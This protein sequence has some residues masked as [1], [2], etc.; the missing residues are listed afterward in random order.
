MC[1]KPRILQSVVLL[2]V[3]IPSQAQETHTQRA[4]THLSTLV[5]HGTDRYGE[6]QSPIWVLNLDLE[7]LNCFP[8]YNDD[9]ERLQADF[10]AGKLKLYSPVVPYGTGHRVL[11]VSQRPAGCSNPYVDQPT[12]RAALL[13]DQL[14]ESATFTPAV[15]A[16]IHQYFTKH[17]NEE[18]GLL[19]WGVHVS[20]DVYNE[21]YSAADGDQHELLGILPLW[22]DL[23]RMEPAVVQPYLKRF[24]EMHTDAETGQ[25]DR[26]HDT[27]GK[28][29]GFAMAAGEIILA[30]AYLHTLEPDG[31]WLD[32]AL[33]VAHAHWDNRDPATNLFPNRAYGGD[34]RFDRL[35]ADTSVPGLWASRVLMAGRLTGSA[36]L[37]AMAR[38]ALKAWARYGWDEEANLPWASLL[39]DGT[40]INIQR[41]NAAQTYDKFNPT[42][43]MELWKDYIYGFESPLYMAMTYAM[44]A[45]W[46]Q[47][48]ELRAHAVRLAE[49]YRRALPANGVRG[50]FAANYGQV[51]SF[52]V[53]MDQLTG[54]AA[55]RDAARQ[56]ADEAVQHL[57]AGTLFR[58]FA[59]RT[60]YTAIEGAGYLVQALIEL[61]TDPAQLRTLRDRNI[62]MWNL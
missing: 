43:H 29:L 17:M 4:L 53:A 36:E 19:N 42:G 45:T 61:E 37:T 40:A 27:G 60:H 21:S 8:K 39:P 16:Y 12:M 48:E 62:F 14:Q 7:T 18:T 50:T 11:R 44:A 13:A 31:P 52:F 56:A 22:P 24:W 6:D 5:E 26:H 10:E 59:N 23:H 30:A 46:L 2:C 3:A 20:Y 32:R 57:W 1:V 58:G 55:Y 41:D 28:G 49:C 38:D 47:D 35:H 51:I 33:Q 9:V 15:E 25:I 54:N 34:D